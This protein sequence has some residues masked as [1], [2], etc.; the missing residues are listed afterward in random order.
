MTETSTSTSAEVQTGHHLRSTIFSPGALISLV[1]F[2]GA[3]GAGGAI[4]AG[5]P[6]G[7]AAAGGVFV[8][9]LMIVTVV[10]MGKAKS[11]FYDAYAQERGL[12]WTSRG[13]IAGATPLLRRGD[14]RRADESFSGPLPG[15]LDGTIALYTYEE[16]G[17]AGAGTGQTQ[18]LHHFTV[19][20]APLPDLGARL[21]ALFVQRRSGFHFLD[22]AEDVF[23]RTVRVEL[24]SAELDNRCEIFADPACD[25]NWLRQ[26]FSPT[27]VDFLASQTPKGFA[28]EIEN[29]TLCVNVNRHRGKADELD[30]LAKAAGAVATRIR[31]EHAE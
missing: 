8:L 7:A 29:G 2:A 23:R 4:A 19:V 28:F 21:P 25:Q 14:V 30:E 27:F 9:W 12:T 22:G 17:A 20:M 18:E 24:E 13:A 1:V 6:V 11:A 26:L 5:P 3:A 15:G 10:G 16:R 31:E